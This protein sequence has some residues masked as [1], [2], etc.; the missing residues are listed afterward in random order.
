M[1]EARVLISLG[2]Q[3]RAD[4]GIKVRQP[5]DEVQITNYKL[6][7]EL[8]EI[9]KEEINIKNINLVD[10]I[11]DIEDLKK[12][13]WR[14]IKNASQNY[15]VLLNANIS[16]DLKLEGQA[17]E[18]IRAIQEMRKEAGYEVDNRIKV[19]Y[20]GLSKVFSEFG[21]MIAK[22]VLA[23]GLNKGKI[24]DSDL[25]KEFEIDGE[26]IQICIKK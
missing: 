21:D 9:V 4:A 2:L 8:E 7:K 15:D 10:S 1:H 13:G 16:E 23:D 22:E 25:E 17:R 11:S 3:M 26:K 24:D 14:H 20:T 6:R 5:L 18:V 19:C 12:N